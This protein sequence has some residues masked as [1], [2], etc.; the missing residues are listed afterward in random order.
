VRGPFWEDVDADIRLDVAKRLTAD[1]NKAFLQAA[2]H[3]VFE[4]DRFYLIDSAL[5]N[6]ERQF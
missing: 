3:Q 2:A 4:E 5:S 1:D 6:L